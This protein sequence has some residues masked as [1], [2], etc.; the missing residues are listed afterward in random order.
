MWL[1]QVVARVRDSWLTVLLKL[2]TMCF[3]MGFLLLLAVHVERT[4]N[5]R[6]SS[7]VLAAHAVAH[8][9]P[10]SETERIDPELKRFCYGTEYDYYGFSHYY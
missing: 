1:L 8:S 5:G 4:L 3:V 6:S 7:G 2:A 9:N 10:N